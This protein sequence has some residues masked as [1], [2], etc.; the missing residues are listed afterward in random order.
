MQTLNC[1][2]STSPE[3]LS[4][5]AL[6][7]LHIDYLRFVSVDGNSSFIVDSLSFFNGVE[8]IDYAVGL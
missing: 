1:S 8:Y 4:D 5:Q 2:S 3:S 7:I 6:K